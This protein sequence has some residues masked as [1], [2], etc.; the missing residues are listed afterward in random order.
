MLGNALGA[1]P[2]VVRTA[3]V[4]EP[5]PS[6]KVRLADTRGADEVQLD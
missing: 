1:L 2:P 4:S 5:D 3:S 6:L